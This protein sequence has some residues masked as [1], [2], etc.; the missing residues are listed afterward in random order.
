[1]E[2]PLFYFPIYLLKKMKFKFSNDQQWHQCRDID[3]IHRML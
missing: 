3:V 2:L 1:M